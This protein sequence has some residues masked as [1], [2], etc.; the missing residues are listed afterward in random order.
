MD[1]ISAHP[2]GKVDVQLRMDY[3]PVFASA[4]H[5]FVMSIIARYSILSRESPVGST[6]LD[7]VIFL[8]CRLKPSIMF[9]DLAFASDMEVHGVEKYDGIY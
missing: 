8:N 3:A 9:D 1:P 4:G 7:F 2:A 6:D 5:F